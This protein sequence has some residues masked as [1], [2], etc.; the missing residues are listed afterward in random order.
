MA[1]RYRISDG[2]LEEAVKN[3]TSMIKVLQYLGIRVA[4]GSHYHYGKRVK[5]LGLD[6][7]HFLGQGHTKNK[8]ALNRKTA[9]DIL[10]MLPDG[11]PRPKRH[12]LLRSMVE[13]GVVYRCRL[14]STS[15]WNGLDLTLHIDHID[16]N[17]LNN[18]LDNLR[19]LCPNC[20][21]Q[22]ENTNK[23]HKYRNMPV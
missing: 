19:F 6:T 4:G 2:Q 8:K 7:S 15:C 14:C 12:Q 13:K 1:K 5:S 11:S 20:H 18:V 17:F 9:D 21:S 23:P 3:S 16:G 10:V 22:Q